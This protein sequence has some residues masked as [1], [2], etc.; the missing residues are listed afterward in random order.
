MTRVKA[1]AIEGLDLFPEADSGSR[2]RTL[3]SG[4]L[5]YT[6]TT[7]NS[8][9][10]TTTTTLEAD[11]QSLKYVYAGSVRPTQEYVETRYRPIL[12]VTRVQDQASLITPE[13]M[14]SAQ[15]KDRDT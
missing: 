2:G 9:Q 7:S 10:Q 15:L 11:N 6:R 1:K 8:G 13:V 4:R 14:K 3:I 12:A 5:A